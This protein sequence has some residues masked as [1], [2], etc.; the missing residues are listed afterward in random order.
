MNVRNEEACLKAI[1]AG[2]N[3][4]KLY[5]GTS[6]CAWAARLRI[7][8]VGI[9]SA[10]NAGRIV[11]GKDSVA[12]MSTGD[13]IFAGNILL[14]VQS[15]IINSHGLVTLAEARA[16]YEKGRALTYV[17]VEGWRI[18]RTNKSET[19]HDFGQGL[20]EARSPSNVPISIGALTLYLMWCPNLTALSISDGNAIGSN[21]AITI[22]H[23]CPS[24][25]T[26]SIGTA[27]AIGSGG[28][29]AIGQHLRSLTSLA[30]GALNDLGPD[31]AKAIAQ[32]CRLVATL[33]IGH[34]NKIG[35]D[36]TAAIAQYC[37]SRLVSL[38]IGHGNEVGRQGAAA[39]ARHCTG[40]RHAVIEGCPFFQSTA[41][42]TTIE[43]FSRSVLQCVSPAH[44]QLSVGAL[45]LLLKWCPRLASLTISQG[46]KIGCD[47]AKCLA[48]YGKSMTSL[49]IGVGNE[50]CSDGAI[51]IA[52]HCTSLRFLSVVDNLIGDEGGKAF[53]MALATNTNLTH[54]NLDS[55]FQ[56][57]E[58]RW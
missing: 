42:D 44:F 35:S 45:V 5:K 18:D 23:R 47:G 3:V 11:F 26:L 53:S 41:L 2:A 28:A 10:A 27:N 36:G 31:G 25:T 21:G 1:S 17:Q 50:I 12:R 58:G 22:A 15:L 29:A 32:H 52:A 7:W 24:L 33:N 14:N 34:D 20:R 43:L 49:T 30:I 54:L 13:A 6:L 48:R 9:A 37:G 55:M 38:V 8:D 39:I 4:D 57:G 40:L 19:I 51:A 56:R 16:I 46:N